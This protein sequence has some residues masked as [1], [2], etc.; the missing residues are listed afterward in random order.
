[1][2]LVQ[3]LFILIGAI[4]DNYIF[5]NLMAILPLELNPRNTI[6]GLSSLAF[7][8]TFRHSRVFFNGTKQILAR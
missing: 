5:K 6:A 4:F 1:M 2:L 3:I 8:S 7:I